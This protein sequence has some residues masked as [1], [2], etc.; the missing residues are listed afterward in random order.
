MRSSSAAAP[1]TGLR[2]ALGAL[3]AVA[4]LGCHVTYRIPDLRAGE[5]H[6]VPHPDEG[7]DLPATL[8]VTD[9][10]R[11]QF[12]TPRVC[13]TVEVVDMQSST[14][15]QV[16]PNLATFV[17]GVIA[18][19][20]GA[21]GTGSLIATRSSTNPA[22]AVAPVVLATGLVFAIG[23]F[24]RTST[25]RTYGPVQHIER[26]RRELPCGQRPVAARAATLSWRG[27]RARGAVD[28]DGY[29]AISPYAFTDAFAA[30]RGQ[31]LDLTAAVEL[32]AGGTA[33][34]QVVVP[35]AALIA[36]KDAFLAR[37]G[38]DTRWETLRKVPRVEAG[39][40]RVSRTTDAGQP[41]LRVVLPL[42]N[43]GPGDAWQVRGVIAT[44][45]P[46]VDGRIIY[47][48][49]VP[50]HGQATGTL[51]IPLSAETDRVLAGSSIELAVSLIDADATTPAGP[52]RFHGTI[53]ND[54]PR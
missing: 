40:L 44:D 35:T 47:V 33:S 52:V 37:T 39:A 17:V 31:P 25:D 23:P 18:A 49:R 8:L 29:F 5:T 36:G 24:L 15:V 26:S 34:I 4:L 3:T 1:R 48:G 11:F 19:G 50:A 21:I 9:D 53:L 38:L 14:I 2:P 10:G 41:V 30:G 20:A 12:V 45:D 22:E 51:D 42:T 16:R 6:L 46:E 28:A 54:V 13:P 27:L 7:R 43:D 32:A